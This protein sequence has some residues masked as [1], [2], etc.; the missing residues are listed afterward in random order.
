MNAQDPNSSPDNSGQDTDSSGEDSDRDSS[1]RNNQQNTSTAAT[2]TPTKTVQRRPSL[3]IHYRTNQQ[4]PPLPVE[5]AFTLPSQSSSSSS[6]G[7][8]TLMLDL[9]SP[10]AKVHGAAT[11]NVY[12]LDGPSADSLVGTTH[13]ARGEKT[14][15]NSFACRQDPMCFRFEVA[16]DGGTGNGV[17]FLQGGTEGMGLSMRYGC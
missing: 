15:V 13:F 10:D 7:P 14:T 17:S 2:P 8:C 16:D 4:V 11:I 12:A 9:T 5:L 1:N 3:K 6:G